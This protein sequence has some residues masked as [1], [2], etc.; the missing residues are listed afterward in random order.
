MKVAFC[1]YVGP[2]ETREEFEKSFRE[3]NRKLYDAIAGRMDAVWADSKSMINYVFGVF[4]LNEFGEIA[5][6]MQL[7]SGVALE[8]Y[9]RNAAK[10]KQKT[11]LFDE[12]YKSHNLSD[13]DSVFGKLKPR[14]RME[15]PVASS[16]KDA[17]NPME[18]DENHIEDDNEWYDTY[19]GLEESL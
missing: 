14:Q 6:D 18:D 1:D 2:D 17:M 16:I 15:T 3:N 11:Y 9:I 7:I 19:D 10:K 4:F 8:T 12:T 13:F 5:S